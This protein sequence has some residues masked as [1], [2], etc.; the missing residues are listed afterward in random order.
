MGL[1][2]RFELRS[3]KNDTVIEFAY[4]RNYYEL[5]QYL[6]PTC[7]EDPI[8]LSESD[9]NE[10]LQKIQPIAELL[11][12]YTLNEILYFDDNGYDAKLA[13]KFYNNEFSPATAGSSF[14]GAKLIDLYNAL[15]SMISV[16]LLNGD[17]Y[18]TYSSDR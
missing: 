3:R 17:T 18:I 1:D 7:T 9:L 12:P 2:A 11:R 10:L 4:F 13:R 8:E 6:N 15:N 5:D 14:A 16:L